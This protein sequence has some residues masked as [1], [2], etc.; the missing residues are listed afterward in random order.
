MQI[1]FVRSGGFAGALR[2]VRG[3]VNLKNDQPE[4]TADAAYHRA[5]A[6]D[7]TQQLRAGAD[8]AELCRAVEQIQKR[9]ARSADLDH[10]HITVEAENG[11][12]CDVD[13]NTSGSSNELEGV[14]PAVASFIRWVR[15]ES[16]KIQ[17]HRAA[18]GR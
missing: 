18:A 12:K 5:L 4:I 10:Y 16:R 6:P 9:T 13:L 15:E 17:A 11:Q 8:P 14:P 3:T 1:S 7:E 2:T